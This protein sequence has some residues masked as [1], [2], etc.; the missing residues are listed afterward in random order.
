MYKKD[1]LCIYIFSNDLCIDLLVLHKAIS[2][3]LLAFT[4]YECNN[5]RNDTVL[6][7][8]TAFNNVSRAG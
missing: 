7:L 3:L 5:T 1:N 6:E 8:T 2:M 4:Q